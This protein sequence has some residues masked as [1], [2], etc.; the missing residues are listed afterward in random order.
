MSYNFETDLLQK[1][2]HQLKE[3]IKKYK[4]ETNND[5]FE[6]IRY[7]A[8]LACKPSAYYS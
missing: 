7:V 3:R 1:L 2:N 4:P 8:C 5:L 6:K